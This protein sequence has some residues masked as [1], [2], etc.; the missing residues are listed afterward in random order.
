VV[1]RCLGIVK[2]IT[3]SLMHAVALAIA[4]FYRNSQDKGTPPPNVHKRLVT[5]YRWSPKTKLIVEA[6]A[7][8][9]DCWVMWFK[10]WLKC[11][12]RWTV[13]DAKVKKKQNLLKDNFKRS[14]ARH[15]KNSYRGRP[16]AIRLLSSVLIFSVAIQGSSW[17]P[18]GYRHQRSR[19]RLRAKQHRPDRTTNT[20]ETV[21]VPEVQV[22]QGFVEGAGLEGHLVQQRTSDQQATSDDKGAQLPEGAT[23]ET[24]LAFRKEPV[25]IALKRDHQA[26]WSNQSVCVVIGSANPDES[27]QQLNPAQQADGE[28][29]RVGSRNSN[30]DQAGPASKLARVPRYRSKTRLG[31]VLG[32]VE[33]TRVCDINIATHNCY[34]NIRSELIL[35]NMVYN[36]V[37]AAAWR[38][39]WARLPT[40]GSGRL[41]RL[42]N[43]R[44]LLTM[45]IPDL[46]FGTTGTK[47][48]RTAPTQ[49]FDKPNNTFYNGR[50]NR[51]RYLQWLKSVLIAL[52]HNAFREQSSRGR[53]STVFNTQDF[54]LGTTTVSSG[55]YANVVMYISPRASKRR[56]PTCTP[57][58]KETN[59]TTEVIDTLEGLQCDVAIRSPMLTL[60]R[61]IRR[62][63]AFESDGGTP[64]SGMV[65]KGQI[66]KH[67][68]NNNSDTDNI[69]RGLTHFLIAAADAA[70]HTEAVSGR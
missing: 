45:F 46:Q 56:L 12:R 4:L 58:P 27:N 41:I 25:P 39:S 65:P 59:A 44:V 1:E 52:L 30:R 28:V 32:N 24:T 48:G 2:N 16:S 5:S 13:D 70:R 38:S 10:S 9:V 47:V 42:A 8:Q 53:I 57:A 19:G 66:N 34:N 67:V 63:T 36:G 6:F 21:P 18:P 20:L 3:L 7:R 14:L 15:I 50:V 23:S 61:E 54:L 43:E 35:N 33:G 62:Y 26:S 22:L 11:W 51:R 69:S 31:A 68:N 29:I 37:D 60:Q 49:V 64:R 40:I 17:R 55:M